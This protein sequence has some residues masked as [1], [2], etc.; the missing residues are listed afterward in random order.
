M[1]HDQ[2]Q[3]PDSEP[4]LFKWANTH[5]LEV[6]KGEDDGLSWP[7]PQCELEGH[8][9]RRC[10]AE[11]AA[12]ELESANRIL[13]IEGHDPKPSDEI[14]LEEFINGLNELQQQIHNLPESDT[15]KVS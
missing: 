8:L 5:P 3:Q 7:C 4:D 12:E 1:N 15:R 10:S 6:P 14:P 2:P 9:C 11:K 13:Q